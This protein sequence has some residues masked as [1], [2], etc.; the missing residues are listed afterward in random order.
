M[1]RLPVLIVLITW[2]LLL[3][4]GAKYLQYRAENLDT[5]TSSWIMDDHRLYEICD[6]GRIERM[7][8]LAGYRGNINDKGE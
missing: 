1:I 7:D 2:L 5:E 6:A 3:M 4:A 8:V